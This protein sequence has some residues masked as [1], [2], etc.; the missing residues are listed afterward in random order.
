MRLFGVAT[1]SVDKEQ[2]R[3]CFQRALGMVLKFM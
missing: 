1:A 3:F 2:Q